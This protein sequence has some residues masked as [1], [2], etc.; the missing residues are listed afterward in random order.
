M[1]TELP[2]NLIEVSFHSGGRVQS[3]FV[4][5]ARLALRQSTGGCVAMF[6]ADGAPKKVR[7]PHEFEY[8]HDALNVDDIIC[9][10][11][12]LLETGW[13]EITQAARDKFER[14][15]YGATY[16]EIEAA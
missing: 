2:Q 12:P 11:N 5:A 16:K 8:R 13:R 9:R 1:K 3:S 15:F 4:S 10:G 7:Y 6:H 14:E